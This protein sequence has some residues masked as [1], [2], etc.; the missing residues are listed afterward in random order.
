[1][2]HSCSDVFMAVETHFDPRKTCRGD[3]VIKEFNY[4]GWDLVVGPPEQSLS[5]ASGTWG[6]LMAGCRKHL[7]FQPLA[8]AGLS[9]NVRGMAW[10]AEPFLCG[11]QL[12][13][14]LVDMLLFASYHRSGFVHGG[15][16]AGDEADAPRSVAVHPL[17]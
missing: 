5:S 1:M 2:C 9:P 4:A 16:R 14:Q 13:M 6:G 10:E 15:P 12:S 17:R 3:Q 11:F 7:S 8:G